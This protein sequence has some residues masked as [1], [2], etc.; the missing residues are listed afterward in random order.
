MRTYRDETAEINRKF[1]QHIMH[2][3]PEALHECCVE[4]LNFMLVLEN[5]YNC[6]VKEKEKWEK[7]ADDREVSV[8]ALSIICGFLGLLLVLM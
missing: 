6:V 3:N 2:A 8:I 4:V 5:E 7:M 1:S